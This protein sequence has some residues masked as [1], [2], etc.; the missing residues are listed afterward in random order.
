MGNS[1]SSSGSKV[2]ALEVISLVD[3]EVANN[4]GEPA[5]TNG[6]AFPADGDLGEALASLGVSA[7][8]V[9]V[10]GE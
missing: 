2:P 3:K 6:G 1:G 9:P 7:E 8:G 5:P 4:G 10:A